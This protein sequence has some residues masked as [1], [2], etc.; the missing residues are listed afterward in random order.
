VFNLLLQILEDGTLTDAK[1]RK[2]N[3]SN[4]IVILTSNLGAERMM[5]ESSLGFHA[6]SKSD[7]KK[8]DEVHSENAEAAEI[9]LGK[10]MRPELVN[11]FDTV[12][13]F[14][15]LT[16]RHISKIFDNMIDELQKR[17]IPKGIHLDIRPAAKKLIIEKGYSEK[18][19]ARPLRRVI[20]D[21]L[22]HRIAD[23]ILSGAYEKGSVLTV[24]TNNGEVS[25][26]IAKEK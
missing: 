2:I 3:F 22:E 17:L 9:A 18:F 11:R 15:A 7:D 13:T 14:R 6:T 24:G 25:I 12:I 4:A 23:G 8:L 21:E 26:N 16:R 10:I 19:G 20:Q 5:K 1:G